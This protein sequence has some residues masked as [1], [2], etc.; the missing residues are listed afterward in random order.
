MG[1]FSAKDARQYLQP[2][3]E[4]MRTN[5]E[6][7]HYLARFDLDYCSKNGWKGIYAILKELDLWARNGKVVEV[8]WY[9]D[10]AGDDM[11]KTA[12]SFESYFEFEFQ[13]LRR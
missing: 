9:Y 1:S 3:L 4:S 2:A 13:Y 7:H 8:I 5:I 6:S 10:N 12:K 11:L